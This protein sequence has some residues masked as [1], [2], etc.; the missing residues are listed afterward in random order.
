M[1]AVLVQIDGYDPVAGAPVTLR[2]ASHDDDRLCHL[3]D[4][5]WW[6]QLGQ[7]PTLR[8]DLFDGG[9]GGKI[10][11]PQSELTLSFEDWPNLP[12]YMLADA[13]IQLWVG[14]LGA[15]WGAFTKRFDGRVLSQPSIS[16]GIASLSFAVD[17][18]WLDTPLLALYAGTGGIEG[19]AAQKGL[20]KPLA[21]GAPRYVPGQ[22][23]DSINSVVQLSAYGAVQTVQYALERLARF[24]ASVGN[25]ASYAALVAATIPAGGWGT[26]LAS[27]LVRHG[28]PPEGM[29]SY[30]MQGDTAGP[31]GWVR[32]PG[33]V[34][35]R[36]ALLSG[37]TGHIGETSLDALD[38]ARPW[39]LSIYV[40]E[41]TTAREL[42]QR[43]A[44]S[45]NAVAGVDWLGNLFVVPL[46]TD[47]GFP[48]LVLDAGGAALPPVST[49]EQLA[50]DAPFWRLT[51]GAQPTWQVHP[52]S[53][54][55][56]TAVLIDRG[57]FDA[58]ESYR[59]GHIVNL[60]NG[61]RF[62]YVNAAPSSGHTPPA[63]TFPP[64]D[65]AADIYWTQIAPPTTAVAP[66]GTPLANLIS[67]LS[68]IAAGKGRAWFQGTP[69]SA[70]ESSEQDIWFDTG[71]GNFMY[72]RVPG[73]G[74]ISFGGTVV[75]FGGSGA[76]VFR[77]WAPAA[78]Q[79]IAQ[80]V[81][82]AA[83]AIQQAQAAQA[84]ASAA[85]A[86][87]SAIDDDG[88]L[89]RGE[90]TSVLIPKA[91]ALE[92]SW[93]DLDAQAATFLVTTERAAA[94]A[95][96]AAWLAQLAAIAPAWN[97]DSVDSPVD[98]DM[99]Q[100]ALDAYEAA[101]SAL[102]KA[103]VAA[104]SK[105][106]QYDLIAGDKPPT[107]ADNTAANQVIPTISPPSIEIAADY[108]GNVD[109]A[110]VLKTFQITMKRGGVDVTKDNAASYILTG[111]S[112]GC[113]SS[114]VTV[115]STNGS[116]T[117]GQGSVGPGWSAPGSFIVIALW[118]GSQ[119]GSWTIPVTKR[120]GDPPS[121]GGSGSSGYVKTGNFGTSSKT[122]T[123]TSYVEIGR[124]INMRKGAGETIR[125]TFN[126]SYDVAGS[127]LGQN[128][129]Y[130][131]WRYMPA[132]TSSPTDFPGGAATGSYATRIHN[133]T[134]G[135]GGPI[136]LP[137]PDDPPEWEIASGEVTCNR[138][139]AP[140]DGDYDLV[141]QAALVAGAPPVVFNGGI[142]TVEIAP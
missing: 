108:N 125:A 117:K 104:A 40:G 137:G 23:I 99:Y 2:A 134:G 140:A 19:E 98:R 6:P 69:P 15:A 43:I 55:A 82:Q 131:R 49:V 120:Q 12:R 122:L 45:V 27:G 68:S 13:R 90:K 24:G 61:A 28:A 89:D 66:D 136:T 129:V 14:E 26:C 76:I 130:V 8:Y 84:I 85:V 44:A 100:T 5:V 73:N 29:L 91:R 31:D 86:R 95:K 107:N 133:D 16:N 62:L 18:R 53:D 119:V 81:A 88:V 3:N 114:N 83:Q 121:G 52:L 17:D 110:A 10:T 111:F 1:P 102:S 59:E 105:L 57:L 139:A 22:M 39:P 47:F 109:T 138:N 60:A 25:F 71:N 75:T 34:I 48:A 123:S 118:N 142:G 65:P 132:G 33:Q 106:A 77:P 115:N 30:Q 94:S 42:I 113:T 93:A 4:V 141:L 74:R 35:K 9:F 50:I 7:L 37:G 97:D 64:A 58:A 46:P 101:L 67:D 128:A 116:A 72:R 127:N 135:G 78:D 124:I 51:M 79:R 80:V 36:I 112:G 56:F 54:V 20:A 11:S 92:A 70:A 21:I 41:Q 32:L 96:R 103:N 63:A 87:L 126:G 38:A